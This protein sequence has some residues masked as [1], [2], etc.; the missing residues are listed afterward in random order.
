MN[1]STEKW[2]A[3]AFGAPTN[4]PLWLAEL[5][6]RMSIELPGSLGVIICGGG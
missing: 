3:V 2:Q 4:S 1:K 5:V 6:P